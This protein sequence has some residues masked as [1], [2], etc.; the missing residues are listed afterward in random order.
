MG[1]VRRKYASCN[2]AIG[3]ASCDQVVATPPG[4]VK[5]GV[6]GNFRSDRR[7]RRDRWVDF[8][9]VLIGAC[10][11]SAFQG[12][13]FAGAGDSAAGQ[14]AQPPV[15][16]AQLSEQV[17]SRADQPVA[18]VGAENGK[19]DQELTQEEIGRSLL[20]RFLEAGRRPPSREQ[21]ARWIEGLG[22]DSYAT[23][24]RSREALARIGLAAFDQL[25]EACHHPD[26]EIA[27]VAR[28]L[29]SGLDV[30]WSSTT[31][32]TR[33]RALLDEYGSRS[34]PLRR[35]VLE[36]LTRLPAEESFA[37]LV[38]LARY[39]PNRNLGR[40]A[41]IA[42]IE[43]PSTRANVEASTIEQVVGE[44]EQLTSQWLRQYAS[45]LRQEQVDWTAW[46]QLMVDAR[47]RIPN[48][49]SP[50][51]QVAAGTRTLD[52]Q[53]IVRLA[54]VV[55]EKGTGG[56]GEIE[57]GRIAQVSTPPM[58]E[59]ALRLI[60]DQ[61]DLIPS[62][63]RELIEATE[64]ALRSHFFPVVL[65]I[66]RQ[67][68]YKM[69]QSPSLLYAVAQAH[70]ELGQPVV[71]QEIADQA[72]AI[73]PMTSSQPD[74]EQPSES[75]LERR[76]ETHL[77]IGRE[78]MERGRFDWSEREF[79]SVIE[80]L[81][82]NS[83]IAA[84]AR[85]HLKSML[86]ELLRHEEVVEVLQPLA[87]RLQK[88]DTLKRILILNQVPYP[89][90]PSLVAYHRGLAA[91]EQDDLKQARKSF[92]LAFGLDPTNIDILISMYRLDGD[93]EW[94]Q[95]VMEELD[96]NIRHAEK[97]V[98]AARDPGGLGRAVDSSALVANRLNDYAWLV[99]NTE[100]DYAQALRYSQES[101]RLTPDEPALMDTCARCYFALGD[102]RAAVEMQRRAV[103]EMPHSPTLQRQ[104][105]EFESKLESVTAS[106]ESSTP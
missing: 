27:I 56:F 82:L 39:E 86:A 42:A 87:D 83:P 13:T 41:A 85:L 8:W 40:S 100:G 19:A 67:H 60:V 88:D 98:E 74:G 31:D 91:I 89:R 63:T 23:R 34:V 72:F 10:G 48:A 25:R 14:S 84:F 26:N 66:H 37:A 46:R 59:E 32:S 51:D 93:D 47:D 4:E 22:A 80:C 92:R 101:L 99:S 69:E 105:H 53:S 12:A 5:V 62:R 104:L 77:E 44:N 35:G 55:A 36:E 61:V 43:S 90:I 79:R 70:D 68:G 58:P 102:Y 71:A 95:Y 81:E 2:Q 9:C 94:R 73:D 65:A 52:P 7:D 97:S 28:Q 15:A 50:T 11:F 20:D 6:P 17:E 54:F 75:V 30:Q 18:S 33:V 96:E 49:E 76:A 1:F 24:F 38:R 103:R 16:E 3:P 106:P 21:I 45:D 64:W 29:T 57:P 78:L